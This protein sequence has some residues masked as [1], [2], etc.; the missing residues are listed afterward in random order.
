MTPAWPWALAL[1]IALGALIVSQVQLREARGRSPPAA[2]A[3]VR[4]DPVGPR[5]GAVGMSHTPRRLRPR[6]QPKGIPAIF[7]SKT[8][9]VITE[10][11]ARVIRARYEDA[12]RRGMPL[13]VSSD[14][15]IITLHGG[16]S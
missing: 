2:G 1:T 3:A 6:R 16:A 14:I 9:P 15:E 13:V 7:R 10:Q 5:L 8:R 12:R 4:R 11:E